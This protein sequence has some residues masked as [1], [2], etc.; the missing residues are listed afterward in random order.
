[1]NRINRMYIIMLLV[2]LFW[3]GSFATAEHVIT[4]IPSI[5]TATIRF[6]LAGCILIGIVFMKSE[7]NTSLLLKNW[8]GLLFVSLTGIFGYNV[9]FFMGLNY[10]STLNGS[11]IIATMPVFVTLGAILF[12]KESWSI[13]VGISLTLSLVGVIVVITGG[14]MHILMSFSFNKGDLLFIAALTCGVL[15]SLTGKKVMSGVS[16][17]L[18]TMSMTVLGTVFLAGLSLYE[19][20]WGKV[21]TLSLQGWIEMLY[22][23]ICGTLVGY[24]VFNKGVEELGASK[25]SIYL[26]LTPIVATGI[27]VVLYGAAV[28]WQQ[29]VGMII[30]LIGVYIATVQSNKGIKK[31]SR[32]QYVSK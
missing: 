32:N 29:I 24:I 5:T 19:D 9:F 18:T 25:A 30:V 13:K 10:T 31:F 1:M 2:P 7:W 11:L 28:T 15:Y 17:L 21:A 6:G 22:M 4:E 20:G 26:N 14:S 16:P 8:K 12:F 27:S 23:V 3:G